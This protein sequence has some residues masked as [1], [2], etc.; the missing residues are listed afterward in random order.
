MTPSGK[1]GNWICGIC[2]GIDAAVTSHTQGLSGTDGDDVGA[3]PVFHSNAGS[4]CA[5]DPEFSVL[6]VV[7]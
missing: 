1:I 6:V 2:F 7:W 5:S 4:R 3:Y